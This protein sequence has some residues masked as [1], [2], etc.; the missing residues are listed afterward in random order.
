MID[1]RFLI[2]YADPPVSLLGDCA[3][4]A[5]ADRLQAR[6]GEGM[7]ETNVRGW[8]QVGTKPVLVILQENGIARR[9]RIVQVN[10]C[11]VFAEADRSMRR[12]GPRFSRSAPSVSSSPLPRTPVDRGEG[13]L[14]AGCWRRAVNPHDGEASCPGRRRGRTGP[15]ACSELDLHVPEPFRRFAAH[16][17]RFPCAVIRR[18]VRRLADAFALIKGSLE[19]EVPPT[20]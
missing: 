19:V 13:V 2:G 4:P 6:E 5:D 20:A 1:V 14:G 18:L 10:V 16:G 15:A 8:R 11:T 17:K 7:L 3:N 12:S 9:C